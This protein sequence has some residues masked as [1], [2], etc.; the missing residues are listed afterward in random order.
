MVQKSGT[1]ADFVSK[2]TCVK[3]NNFDFDVRIDLLT[4]PYDDRSV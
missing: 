2:N 4:L 3:D 1:V